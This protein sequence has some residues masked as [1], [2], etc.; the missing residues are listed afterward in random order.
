MGT[1]AFILGG[2]LQGIGAGIMAQGQQRAEDAKQDAIARREMALAQFR[3]GLDRERDEAQSEL[4]KGEAVHQSGLRTKE[5]ETGAKLD[6]WKSSRQTARSA[7]AQITVAEAKAEID[8]K[9]ERLQSRLRMNEAQAA[10]VRKIFNDVYMAHVEVGDQKIAAD[11]AMVF[12]SKAGKE[13]GRTASGLFQPEGDSG[14]GAAFPAAPRAGAAP[15][16]RPPLDS[17]NR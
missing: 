6:D 8:Q 4:R 2:A 15:A 11:G 14:L 16:N 9:M 12:Y 3:S 7:S 1:G 10:A 5:A 13:I 17:F